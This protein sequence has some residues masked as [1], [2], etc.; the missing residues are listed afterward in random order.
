MPRRPGSRVRAPATSGHTYRLWQAM[1][2][3]RR[4]G[5]AWT[6]RELAAVADSTEAAAR[7]LLGALR[8][9]GY[10]TQTEPWE[11]GTVL[12]DARWRLVRDTGPWPPRLRRDGRLYDPNTGEDLP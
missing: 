10:V 6:V 1:R 4:S 7:R 8:R 2:V 9:H 3:Y 11:R 5:H 12:G